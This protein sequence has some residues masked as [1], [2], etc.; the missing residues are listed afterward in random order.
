MRYRLLGASDLKVS[1]IALGSWLTYGG[2]VGKARAIACIRTALD[3]GINLFDTANVYGRG[4]AESLLG[5][6]LADV[7]RV[8]YVLATKLFF[9]MT[10]SD[11]GL[12]R[13]QVFKQLDASLQRLR[14]DHIDLYQCHRYDPSTPLDETMEA[15]T[16]VVRQGKVRCLGFSEW[17]VDKI[18]AALALPGVARF[19]SSQPQYSMLRRAPGDRIYET[20]GQVQT[21]V[22]DY[23]LGF[24]NPLRL[25]S[26]L[27]YRTPNEFARQFA[28]SAQQHGRGPRVTH[29]AARLPLYRAGGGAVDNSL[30]IRSWRPFNGGRSDNRPALTFGFVL[31]IIDT[32]LDDQTHGVLRWLI[33]LP[34]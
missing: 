5:E 3:L 33:G 23:V 26:T 29:H 31:S 2:G 16:E 32:R 9:P 7:P 18:Q 25:H 1:E 10:Q 12:S 15:L 17:P 28:Q 14:T 27:G 20:R 34:E 11:R 13:A 24:Y 6:A 21:A 22:A 8:S 4:A 19:V 30:R